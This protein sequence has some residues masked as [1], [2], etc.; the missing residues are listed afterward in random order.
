[1]RID[2]CGESAYLITVTA[3]DCRPT[4]LIDAV[5]TVA[6]Q[7]RSLSHSGLVP[8]I[9]E[10]VP[11]HSTVLV[12]CDENL[13]ESVLRAALDSVDLRASAPRTTAE[14][15]SIDVDYSHGEDL[16]SVAQAL[17]CSAQEVIK[18]HTS[19]RWVAAFGGFAPGFMYLVPDDS[20]GPQVSIPRR[21]SPR[22]SV[23]RGS[24]ALADSFSAVY[25]QRSPGGW[26][27]IGRTTA[28][29]FSLDRPQP[30]LIMPGDI[31]HFRQVEAP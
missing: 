16:G 8:G 17:K 7:L 5:I 23:P 31:V 28:E 3:A 21:S 30:S 1:M 2:R 15:V 20:S 10:V 25:P 11:A 6:S 24:V 18:W 22:A 9:R 12:H 29:M 4:P 13:S 27:I 19:T 26:Q 14:V